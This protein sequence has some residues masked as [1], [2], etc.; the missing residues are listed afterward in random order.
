MKKKNIVFWLLFIIVVLAVLG[1]TMF[2]NNNEKTET[3]QNV[4]KLQIVHGDKFTYLDE[5]KD[6]YI[7]DYQLQDITKDNI[8][9]DLILVGD[10]EIANDVYA[11]NICLIIRNGNTGKHSSHELKDMKGYETHISLDDL[12]NDDINELIIS[13]S[14]GGSVNNKVYCILQYE[15]EKISEIFNVKN[16]AGIKVE[17]EFKDN[18]IADIKIEKVKNKMNVDLRD[19]KDYYTK[20]EIYDQNSKLINKDVKIKTYPINNLEKIKLEDNTIGIKTSQN[21]MGVDKTDIIDVIEC[22]LKFNRNK[23]EIIAIES[24]KMGKLL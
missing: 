7:I 18:Y 22:T 8:K 23:F 16:S 20:K 2:L 13:S 15:N 9:D 5:F 19:K 10:K 14:I 21:I 1:M 12:T 6:K 3:L 11:Q 17:G 4:E 24:Q